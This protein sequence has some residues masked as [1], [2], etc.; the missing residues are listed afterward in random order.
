MRDLCIELEN[1]PGA[2][3]EVGEFLAR[4]GVS[5]E[6]GGAWVT[7]HGAVAHFLVAD[8]A[9]A[10]K[11]LEEAGIRVSKESELLVQRLR[12][13]EPGQL[14]MICRRFAEA[15]VNIDV[16]YS[17]H[18]GQLILVVD[19]MTLGREISQAWM[20]EYEKEFSKKPARPTKEHIY[21]VSIDWTGNN[22]EGTKSYSSYRRDYRV[23]A[24]DK[25]A[26]N[27][28]S[29]PAFRGDMSRYNPEELLVASLTSCHML[30]YLHLCSTHGITVSEYQDSATGVLQ[31]NVNGSGQ[32]VRVALQPKVTIARGADPV[33]AAALHQDAHDRCFIARSIS[34]PVEIVPTIVEGASE[35]Q[36]NSE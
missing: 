8:G 13:D 31:L 25:P 34:F 5:I 3:A 29:D 28:S 32:F 16:Q 20:R 22:G 11:A 30:W 17:D 27:G 26:I 10:R 23:S 14:G 9:V 36:N 21:E 12:Q 35:F 19:N 33:L 1:R 18:A 2:L 7:N 4:S 24:G 6:G 15:G